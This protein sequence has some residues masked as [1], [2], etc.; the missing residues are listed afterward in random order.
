MSGELP[1]RNRR[2]LLFYYYSSMLS[3]ALIA[4][5]LLLLCWPRSS[6]A[7]SGSSLPSSSDSLSGQTSSIPSSFSSSD[8][9]GAYVDALAS[10]S[11]TVPLSVAKPASY[12]R[13]AVFVGDAFTEGLL[14]YNTIEGLDEGNL[15][16]STNLNPS[17]LS[18]A[19]LSTD[20]DGQACTLAARV[21]SL[22]PKKLYF[23]LGSNGVAWLD[24][25]GM[26]DNCAA[27]LQ[28]IA[29]ALPDCTIYVQSIFPFTSS[30]CQSNSSYD[31]ADVRAYNELLYQMAVDNGWHFIHTYAA[32]ADG[33]GALPE[34][35]SGDGVHIGPDGYQQWVS[36]LQT[37]TVDA[38][39][40]SSQPEIIVS[41]PSA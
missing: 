36:Y 22:E 5:L 3:A 11:G 33:D 17:R 37:H 9:S 2:E 4:M 20:A 40:P 41:E 12:F 39:S 24:P 26:A 29:K 10:A 34:S 16:A 31:N 1:F 19:G 35:L 15:A 32:L 27:F 14:L 38:Q 13:D 30:L 28:E 21:I 25:Q 18:E 6:A 8:V 7:A 23:M